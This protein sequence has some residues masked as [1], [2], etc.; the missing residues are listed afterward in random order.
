MKDRRQPHLFENGRRPE[1]FPLNGRR[2]QYSLK[3]L[4]KTIM[5]PKTVKNKN[6]GCGT[7]P[8]NLVAF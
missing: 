1:T 3:N 2:A 5:Q 4:K 6:N 7:A 8:V